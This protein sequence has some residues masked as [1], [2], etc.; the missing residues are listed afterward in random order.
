MRIHKMLAVGAGLAVVMLGTSVA[1]ADATDPRSKIVVPTDPNVIVPCS[2]V[3]NEDTVCFTETNG[4]GNPAPI[5]GP[6][7]EQVADDPLFD[8]ITNFFY[9]PDNCGSSDPASC[10]QSDVL[11]TVF[12][13]VMPTLSS[14]PYP[15]FIG[16]GPGDATPA[17]NGCS[18]IGVTPP[19]G[20]DVILELSCVSTTM[21]PCTGML[22]GQEGSAE[23]TPEPGTLLLLGTG[24][25]LMGLF[26]WK[27]RKALNIGRQ[28]QADFAAY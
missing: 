24:L 21:N 1:R 18:P 7:A 26:S 28:N 5:A 8:I 3:V 2:S 14:T 9:E 13:A 15:C 10:P 11:D 20:S 23:L 12:L 6:T 16:Q 25:P 19:P 27:R 4:I 17:F 22:P